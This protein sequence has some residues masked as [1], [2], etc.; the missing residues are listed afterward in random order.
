MVSQTR[1]YPYGDVWTQGVSATPQTDKL[2][3]GQRR[4]G[5]KSGIYYYGSRFYSADSGRFLQAD[6]IVPEPSNPQALNRYSYVVNNPMRYTD[7]TGRCFGEAPVPCPDTMPLRLL[8]F[9][10]F[11]GGLPN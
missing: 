8:S 9:A 6:S 1:Y 3:T 5:A 2:F 11:F 7:P 10:T 4:Y